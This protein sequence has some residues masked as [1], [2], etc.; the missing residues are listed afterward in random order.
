MAAVVIGCSFDKARKAL[1]REAYSV[2]DRR[3]WRWPSARL[4]TPRTGLSARRPRRIA[5]ENMPP[6]KPTVRDAP[7]GTFS[8]NRSMSARVTAATLEAPEQRLNVARYAACV[9]SERG[10]LFGQLPPRQDAPGLGRFEI[11]VA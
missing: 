11:V 7:P 1:P 2:S 6:S 9:R 8:L 4:S 5:N 10:E 3:R